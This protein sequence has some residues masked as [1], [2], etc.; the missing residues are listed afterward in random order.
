ALFS[1]APLLGKEGWE[2]T[3]WLLKTEDI[4][5][6]KDI[7]EKESEGCQTLSWIQKVP[8]IVVTTDVSE[9]ESLHDALRIE[10][11]KARACKLRWEEE[12]ELLQEEQ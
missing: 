3:L 6:M 1:L 5:A 12:K 9:R 4:R 10:W 7:C 2:D 8:G 11:C